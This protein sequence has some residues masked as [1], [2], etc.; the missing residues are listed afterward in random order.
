MKASIK[1]TTA[2]RLD[3]T[4]LEGK[5]IAKLYLSPDG[6]KLRVILPEFSSF[7]QVKMNDLNHLIDFTRDHTTARKNMRDELRAKGFSG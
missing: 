4:D 1:L 2:D 3:V 5:L 7:V 6:T